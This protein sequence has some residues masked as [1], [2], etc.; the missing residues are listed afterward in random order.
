MGGASAVRSRARERLPP[1]ALALAALLALAASAVR[2][3][4]DDVSLSVS[5][6]TTTWNTT[7]GLVPLYG[8]SAEVTADDG[9]YTN[10]YE[11]V[12]VLRDN[13]TNADLSKICHFLAEDQDVAY[14]ASCAA[15]L[16]SQV[17]DANDDDVVSW[18]FAT[19]QP[20]SEAALEQLRL[21]LLPYVS[22]FE[23]NR[24]VSV[25]DPVPQPLARRS[26]RQSGRSGATKH[27]KG[28]ATIAT[29][30]DGHVVSGA[31][32]R[33]A[34]ISLDDDMRVEA[35]WKHRGGRIDLEEPDAGADDWFVD[36]DIEEGSEGSQ[37]ADAP[38]G[39]PV[40]EDLLIDATIDDDHGEAPAPAPVTSSPAINLDDVTLDSSNDPIPW[41]LDRIDQPSLPLNGEFNPG[42]NG[43]EGVHIY[44]LDT[45]ILATHEDFTDRVGEGFS[46]YD[47][48]PTTDPQGH[49]T[50]VSGT[51]MGS[52]HGVA[53][54]AIVH[55]VQVVGASG[56]GPITNVIA[57]LGW[58]RKHVIDNGNWTA[59]ASVS[60][61][62]SS[63][64]ALEAAVESLVS[65]G[66]PLV[67]SAGNTYG[68]DACEQSPG[69]SEYSIT[70]AAS[71]DT[72]EIGS[73]SSIG[74]CVD[75]VAPG[76]SILSAGIENNT[77]TAVLSGTSQATPHVTGAVALI[78]GMYPTWTPEEVKAHLLSSAAVVPSFGS[79]VTDLIVQVQA[80]AIA[81]SA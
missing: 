23:R 79:E 71:D 39:A 66:V 32:K 46:S 43:G 78:R 27:H 10:T 70:V 35:Y 37:D 75:I 25:N 18:R 57:G 76:T 72:D 34:S 1:A 38:A 17:D 44:V 68:G 3:Q 16:Q 50:H 80:S 20:S 36:E 31:P 59:V 11:F 56:S 2:G 62:T 67:A 73:Y 74:S 63:S 8:A 21:D 5:G 54:Q 22:F 12:M 33:S 60:L 81:E 15:S 58:V 52:I 51:A 19:V 14:N 69:N 49:G 9:S 61:G 40:T 55:P 13:V 29:D 64:P 41:G 47:T 77:A 7:E 28:G 65:S 30:P 24:Y 6:S 42:G 48:E 53:R 26:L 4:Q 45:G